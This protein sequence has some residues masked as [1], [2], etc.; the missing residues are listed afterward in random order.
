MSDGVADLCAGIGDEGYGGCGGG[1][2]LREG[3]RLW[4]S[5]HT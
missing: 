4:I 1:G 5:T 2:C 3:A